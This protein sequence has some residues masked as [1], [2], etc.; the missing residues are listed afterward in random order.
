MRIGE[1]HEVQ[2]RCAVANVLLKL[3]IL[4]RIGRRESWRADRGEVLRPLLVV[5]QLVALDAHHLHRD[6]ENAVVVEIGRRERA[7]TGDAHPGV[8]DARR[9]KD[10]LRE[11]GL[12]IGKDL[13]ASAQ[14]PVRFRIARAQRDATGV[15]R[16]QEGAH[17]PGDLGTKRIFVVEQPLFRNA[18]IVRSPR[19]IDQSLRDGDDRSAKDRVEAV[20][21]IA[22]EAP[23]KAEHTFDGV[24]D[25]MTKGHV[26]H[27]AAR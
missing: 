15:V 22:I 3:Q 24:I 20:A 25:S 26:C 23:R 4:A 1:V 16:R 19:S 8:V 21:I 12:Q 13:E 27:T 2:R 18:Q 17:V 5:E 10:A 7:G 14:Q 9:G 11:R 6:A